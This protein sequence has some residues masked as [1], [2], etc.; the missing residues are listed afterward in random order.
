LWRRDKRESTA[1][2]GTL[3]ERTTQVRTQLGNRGESGVDSGQAR[4]LVVRGSG[5]VRSG[6]AAAGSVRGVGSVSVESETGKAAG[7]GPGSSSGGDAVSDAGSVE[8]GTTSRLLAL[9]RK[10]D[11]DRTEN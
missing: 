4:P 6:A 11:Q 10:R 2:L 8:D 7:T 5:T 3:L 1:T 9:K